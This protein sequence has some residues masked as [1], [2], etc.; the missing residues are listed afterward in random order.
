M[1][2]DM[3][4]SEWFESRSGGL[5]RY[6]TDLFGALSKRGDVSV[7]AS[8]FGTPPAI[9]GA[10]SWGPVGGGTRTRVAASRRILGDAH[11]DVVDRHFA[12]YGAP[13]RAYRGT[14]LEVVHF[15]GPWAAESLVA[16]ASRG[17]AAAKRL[18]ERLRYRGA[19]HYVVLSQ[20]FRDVL[21]NDYH[22]DAGKISILAPGVDLERF[23]LRPEPAGS[24]PVV[25]CVRR[26]ERRMGIDVLIRAWADVA[27]RVPGAEL[28]IVGTGTFEKELHE[29]ARSGQ[30]GDSIVFHGRLDD[31]ALG[32][33]YA[34]ATC[35]VVPTLSLEGFGLIALESLAVGRPVVVTDC[36]GLPDAVVDL[37]PSLIVPSGSVEALADRL[38][39][40]LRGSRPSGAECRAHAETFSWSH[41]AD[42][43]I[44]LYA[45]LNVARDRT[46]E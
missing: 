27:A 3:S 26:L 42:R 37:D 31:E 5:N 20:S 17:S 4:G 19:D 22:V 13:K 2:V 11:A 12:L 15:Q 24:K 14:P 36:G 41:V 32:Q 18:F 38:T 21:A 1:R 7:Q 43:H 44:A 35:T 23:T 45:S 39:T 6:F 33:A 16:G 46:S 28:H 9:S 29:L 40:A 34:A 30:H 10:H 25:L 8:S